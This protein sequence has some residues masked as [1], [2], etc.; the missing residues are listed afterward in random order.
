MPF[1]DC[2]VVMI[3]DVLCDLKI[4]L[5]MWGLVLLGCCCVMLAPAALMWRNATKVQ[6]LSGTRCEKRKRD[7]GRGVRAL[8]LG[9]LIRSS[10]SDHLNR[11]TKRTHFVDTFCR[12]RSYSSRWRPFAWYF[13]VIEWFTWMIHSKHDVFNEWKL[14][15]LTWLT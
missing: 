4:I 12:L 8:V 13:W 1:S 7:R 3:I 2:F 15:W 5:I 6:T 11:F 9:L 10:D 14:C